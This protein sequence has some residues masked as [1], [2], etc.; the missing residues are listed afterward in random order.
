MADKPT[1]LRPKISIH[2][3]GAIPLKV[4][5]SSVNAMLDRSVKHKATKS[6]IVMIIVIKNDA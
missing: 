5:M 4:A 2:T 3:R 1:H 6:R